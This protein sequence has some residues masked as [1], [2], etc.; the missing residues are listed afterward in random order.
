MGCARHAADPPDSRCADRRCPRADHPDVPGRRLRHLRRRTPGQRVGVRRRRAPGQLDDPGVYRLGFRRL[1]QPG[2]GAAA[3]QVVKLRTEL[4]PG[5]AEQVRLRPAPRLLS[6]AGKGGYRI[7]AATVIATAQ[8][9][10]QTVTLDAGSA[11]RRQPQRDGA[12]R[13]G[14]GRPGHLG[15]RAHLPR[16]CWPPTRPRPSASSSRPS[17]QVGWVTGPGKTR[18]GS[19]AFSLQVLDASAVLRPGEQ[20]VTSASVHDRPFVPGV[21]VGLISSVQQPRGRADRAALMSGR[22]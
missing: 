4:E 10:Q 15:D 19:G 12:E 20:L 21:P 3:P 9:F 17:G 6:L 11:G 16:C 22:T 13:P 7:V 8:G 1:G 5:A 2:P 14:A 18:S